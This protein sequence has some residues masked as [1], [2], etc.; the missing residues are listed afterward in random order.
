[1][2]GMD[3][4]SGP[5]STHR[6]TGQPPARNDHDEVWLYTD[7]AARGNPGPAA[8]GYRVVT[9]ADQLLR[10]QVDRLGHRTNNQAEYAALIAGLEACQFFTSG[11]VRVGSDSQLMVNQMNGTWR[12]REPELRSLYEAA[13]DRARRFAEVEYQHYPRPHQNITAVDRELN[14]LLDGNFGLKGGSAS[15][16]EGCVLAV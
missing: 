1:M 12:V 14:A 5:P 8:A 6:D 9:V 2:S 15:G 10:S 3:N 16:S 4:D 7:G 13:M 11:R